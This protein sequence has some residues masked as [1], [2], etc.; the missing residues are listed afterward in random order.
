MFQTLT[1]ILNITC[2][3]ESEA[4]SINFLWSA[5]WSLLHSECLCVYVSVCVHMCVSLCVCTCVW[6][7]G[8]WDWTQS[9]PHARQTLYLWTTL[10]PYCAHFFFYPCTI[11]NTMHWSLENIGLLS[12]ANIL[13]IDIFHY[14]MLEKTYSLISLISLENSASIRS[15]QAP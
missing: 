5:H 7:G 13:N 9:F 12:Y 2:S 4:M 14:T 8:D 15:C 6:V 1:S 11:Y 3:V 10:L